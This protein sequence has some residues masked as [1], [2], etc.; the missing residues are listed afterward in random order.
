[1]VAINFAHLSCLIFIVRSIMFDTYTRHG[2]SSSTP[3]NSFK[4]SIMLLLWCEF[5]SS[6]C[7]R[8]DCSAFFSLPRMNQFAVLPSA[9]CFYYNSLDFMDIGN[10][11]SNYNNSF[12]QLI[13]EQSHKMYRAFFEHGK[14]YTF[15][16]YIYSQGNC[17]II[18][19]ITL[20]CMVSFSTI[21]QTADSSYRTLRI[22]YVNNHSSTSLTNKLNDSAEIMTP[23]YNGITPVR[24]ALHETKYRF[25]RIIW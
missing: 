19:V 15:Y 20:I 8:A 6:I 13:V 16:V 12:V 5:M 3:S 17:Y 18:F 2:S 9:H 22:I 21:P 1:M 7:M 10:S 4:S 14:Y 24:M 23:V 25:N 11:T